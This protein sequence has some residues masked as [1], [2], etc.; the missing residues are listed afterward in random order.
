M[1][2]S[3]VGNCAVSA[4]HGRY[5]QLIPVVITYI[6]TSGS[7]KP[8]TTKPRLV[9]MYICTPR[10]YIHT[11]LYVSWFLSEFHN[12]QGISVLCTQAG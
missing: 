1:T 5:S 2:C 12:L 11:W 6:V 4:L 7:W 8:D 10:P 9:K 3:R